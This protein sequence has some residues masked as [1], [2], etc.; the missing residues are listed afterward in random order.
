[1]T[2]P[3]SSTDSDVPRGHEARGVDIGGGGLGVEAPD[4]PG[5]AIGG[6]ALSEGV[7]ADVLGPDSAAG[8]VEARPGRV[9]RELQDIGVAQGITAL[10]PAQNADVLEA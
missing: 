10:A 6:V 7:D 1:M 9:G 5:P 4:A 2:R 3:R 8:P